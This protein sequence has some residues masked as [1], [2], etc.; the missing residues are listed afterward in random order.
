MSFC[1]RSLEN[2]TFVDEMGKDQ[3][4]NIRHKVSEMLEF[5]QVSWATLISLE[6]KSIFFVID[7]IVKIASQK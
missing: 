5:I 1:G 4:I 2:Y 3:G 6:N 7:Q